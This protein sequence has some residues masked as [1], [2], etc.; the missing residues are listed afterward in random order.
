MQLS[1][2]EAASERLRAHA[3]NLTRDPARTCDRATL[4]RELADAGLPVWESL[5]AFEER[6][7]GLP[8]GHAWYGVHWMCV[9]TFWKRA[10]TVE[11]DDHLRYDPPEGPTRPLVWAGLADLDTTMYLDEDGACYQMTLS[12]RAVAISTSFDV[13]LE[14]LALWKELAGAV[15][16]CIILE[17]TDARVLDGLPRVDEASDAFCARHWDGQILAIAVAA[18]R[19]VDVGHIRLY[20]R[21]LDE[22][23]RRA[24][25]A[26]VPAAV[27]GWPN[28]RTYD[29]GRK[30]GLPVRTTY[31]G[32]SPAYAE[33]VT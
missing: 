32:E 7:G 5:L 8:W 26:G 29:L 16:P 13:W 19:S 23:G 9:D 28:E 17:S 2:A 10:R 27:V 25:R 1:L 30:L 6:F 21:D 15:D 22:L 18:G 3:A 14:R 33:Y 11:V 20:G 24:L 4:A 12:E 31:G